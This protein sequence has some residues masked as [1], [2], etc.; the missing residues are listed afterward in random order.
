[1]KIVITNDDGYDQPGLVALVESLGRLGDVTVVAPAG[2]HSH[3]GHRVTMRTPIRVERHESR[4]YVVHGTPADCTRLAV[5]QCV[6][7][8]DWVLSGI[9]PGANLG[10]DVLISGTVGAALQ[11]YFHEIPAVAVST[12]ASIG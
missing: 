8:V 5:K 10:S 12:K 6:P 7:D 2:P 1:M 3:G 11:G 4:T 9:N